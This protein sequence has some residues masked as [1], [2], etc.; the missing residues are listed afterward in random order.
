MNLAETRYHRTAGTGRVALRM[1]A[2][3]TRIRTTAGRV[4]LRIGRVAMR[5]C[6]HKSL[7][8]SKLARW[9]LRH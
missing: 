3:V 2:E 7:L 4:A 5:M 6:L 9:I 8:M 1:N